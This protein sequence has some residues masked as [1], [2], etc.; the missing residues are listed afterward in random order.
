MKKLLL[1]TGLVLLFCSSSFPQDAPM[2]E[3]FGGYAYNRILSAASGE[4][5]HTNGWEA[6]AGWNLNRWFGLKADF[7]GSYCCHQQ[8]LY[9]F[10]GGPQL[11]LRREKYTVFAHGLL[12]G[13]H[14]K[15]MSTTDTDLAWVLGGGVDWNVHRV[16]AIRL[17]QVDYFGTHFFSATQDDLRVSAGLVFRLGKR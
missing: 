4:P 7:G 5:V 17:G 15:G 10:L 8:Y 12:G 3:V 16:V 6:S 2:V 13:A 1:V 14:A 11:S 9:S